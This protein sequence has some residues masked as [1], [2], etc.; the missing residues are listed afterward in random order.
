MSCNTFTSSEI[1]EVCKTGFHVLLDNNK[2]SLTGA[3]CSMQLTPPCIHSQ[4]L[5]VWSQSC[6]IQLLEV[7]EP[8]QPLLIWV[9]NLLQKNLYRVHQLGMSIRKAAMTKTSHAAPVDQLHLDTHARFLQDTHRNWMLPNDKG[10]ASDETRLNN[11]QVQKAQILVI[12][13]EEQL[14]QQTSNRHAGLVVH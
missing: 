12:R 2:P 14:P 11:E 5:K 1:N 8:D 3:S 9:P 13:R 7:S 4:I 10:A 6:R